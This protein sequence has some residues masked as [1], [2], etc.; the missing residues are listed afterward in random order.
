[1]KNIEGSILTSIQNELPFMLAGDGSDTAH[2][3]VK[4]KLYKDYHSDKGKGILHQD[5]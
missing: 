1:M 2:D 5:T 3:L 4:L